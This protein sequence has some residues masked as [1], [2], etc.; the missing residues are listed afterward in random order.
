MCWQDWLFSL[1]YFEPENK[2]ER[3][4]YRIGCHSLRRALVC[5]ILSRTSGWLSAYSLITGLF[6]WTS[7]TFRIF[8]TESFQKQNTSFSKNRKSGN[9][10]TF[11]L[12]F[13]LASSPDPFVECILAACILKFLSNFRT[14]N[15]KSL[16]SLGNLLLFIAPASSLFEFCKA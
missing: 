7:K 11:A 13:L 1:A 4:F 8:K 2:G 14:S 5:V 12:K 3:L 9:L 16:E 10:K 15:R 6:F